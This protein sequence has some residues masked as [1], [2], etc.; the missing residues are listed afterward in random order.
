M[1]RQRSSGRSKPSDEDV[2]HV[3]LRNV[4]E[5]QGESE[6]VLGDL[7]R[8][9]AEIGRCGTE[10]FGQVGFL[11]ELLSRFGRLLDRI[12]VHVVAIAAGT[13]EVGVDLLFTSPG[14]DLAAL[15][16]AIVEAVSN[17]DAVTSE[18]IPVSNGEL[19]A[20]VTL[21]EPIAGGPRPAVVV[22]GPADEFE[23]P[24]EYVQ[25]GQRSVLQALAD[26]LTRWGEFIDISSKL[27]ATKTM[28]EIA[29]EVTQ[30]R[31]E[32]DFFDLRSAVTS[33]DP[34]AAVDSI[35]PQVTTFMEELRS[36]WNLDGIHL[37]GGHDEEPRIIASVGP[38]ID[39]DVARALRSAPGTESFGPGGEN[40]RA[41]STSFDLHGRRG[42]GS[43]VYVW[44]TLAEGRDDVFLRHFTNEL[45][46]LID[47]YV[48][49]TRLQ[50]ES[51]IDRATGQP[52]ENAL[53]AA[54]GM[55]HR[56]EA[57]GV[58]V[59]FALL[60]LTKYLENYDTSTIA[61]LQRQSLT[62]LEERL[63]VSRSIVGVL[64]PSTLYALID[65]STTGHGLPESLVD[66]LVALA[67]EPCQMSN[68][69]IRPAVAAGC[70][71]LGSG[72]DPTHVM[73]NC[74]A[75]LGEAAHVGSG[76]IRW[77]SRA[78]LDERRIRYELE[79]EIEHALGSC[80]FIPYFQPEF[81]LTTGV[82]ESFE[83]LVRWRH[84]T[85]GVL[86]PGAFIPIAEENDLVVHID[87]Q[88]L[89]QS[90]RLF[91]GWGMGAAGPKLRVNLSSTTMHHPMLAERILA[92]CDENRMSYSQLCVEVTETSAMRDEALGIVH[93]REL[94][95]HGVGV[96]L[97]DFGIGTSSL[98]RLR[99]LPITVV[100]M[101]RAFVTPLPG[102]AGDRAFVAALASMARAVDLAITAEGVETEEQRTALIE[103]GFLKAQGFLFAAPLAPPDVEELLRR[104]AT[105]VRPGVTSDSP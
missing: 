33:D 102:D 25:T 105:P 87:L 66:D 40:F 2:A 86:G 91:V 38:P 63:T 96:A 20:R 69:L 57:D 45:G 35:A 52:N 18:P 30:S 51:F 99:L 43:V 11:Q 27:Q 1:K 59:T 95:R 16:A 4:L 64:T 62:R 41:M 100:K 21:L 49:T 92:I 10:Q 84:P 79:R 6:A 31:R 74:Y 3:Q 71:R 67:G 46:T 39:D 55:L 56:N 24:Y 58:L 76:A 85:R 29:A 9:Q 103:L 90:V 12:S 101:D 23:L 72:D 13:D 78:L 80:E 82:I 34:L 50:R 36:G 89:E 47:S 15:R 7:V 42:W 75:A 53:H 60:S 94:R 5:R 28:T 26:G 54:L 61:T 37:Y 8:F 97:D 98:A 88:N 19:F 83:S 48:A 22:L 68:H 77:A 81:S 32:I 104:T 73:Q 70:S 17:A 93:L 65:T 44:S 14:L